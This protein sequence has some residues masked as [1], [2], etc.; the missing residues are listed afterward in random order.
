MIKANAA[1][2]DYDLLLFDMMSRYGLQG[3]AMRLVERAHDMLNDLVHC[4]YSSLY[5]TMS[6]DMALL[7]EISYNK[8]TLRILTE[9]CN[10]YAEDLEDYLDT[11]VFLIPDE[12]YEAVLEFT[13]EES[14]HGWVL[15][16]I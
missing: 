1:L 15:D 12:N 9:W 11:L 2:I 6:V 10:H 16:S 3:F 4:L 13:R 8:E 14:S 5:A 7:G